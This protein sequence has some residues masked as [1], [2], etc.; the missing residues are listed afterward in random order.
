MPPFRYGLKD[1]ARNYLKDFGRSLI[2]LQVEDA[3][4]GLFSQF[5]GIG[6]PI[7]RKGLD[8]YLDLMNVILS[9]KDAIKEEDGSVSY[10]IGKA[11]GLFG[12]MQDQFGYE[13]ASEW[14]AQNIKDLEGAMIVLSGS[15]NKAITASDDLKHGLCILSRLVEKVTSKNL[16]LRELVTFFDAEGNGSI[17]H[18][19][20]MEGAK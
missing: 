5:V 12:W 17:D 6:K 4:I 15:G 13:L 10:P 3:R 9:S 2:E 7:P 18:D 1:L 14:R 11:L 19:E 16:R 8:F 20:F